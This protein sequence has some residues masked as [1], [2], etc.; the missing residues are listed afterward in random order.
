MRTI[1]IMQGTPS[2]TGVECGVAIEIRAI[3]NADNADL[4]DADR[5]P[6]NTVAFARTGTADDADDADKRV[7]SRRLEAPCFPR[8]CHLRNLRSSAV[9]CSYTGLARLVKFS[10]PICGSILADPPENA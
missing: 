6:Q 8:Q 5:V 2:R 3:S 4:A 1:V 7:F 9:Q 10:E